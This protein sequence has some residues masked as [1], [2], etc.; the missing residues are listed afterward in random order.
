MNAYFAS[1]EQQAHPELRGKPVIITPTPCPTGC[2]ITSSYEARAYGIKTG[3]QVRE[4][5]SIYPHIIIRESDTFLY[6]KYHEKLIEIIKNL[7]PFYIVKSIDEL[8]IKLSPQDQNYKNS[9]KFALTIK[10]LIKKHLGAYVRCSIGIAPNIFLA[11][12]AAESKKPD[13]LTILHT[14]ELKS[15]LKKL[16]LTDLCGIAHR[17]ANNLQALGINSPSDFYSTDIQTLKDQLGKIGEYWCLN[18]HGYDANISFSSAP[19]KTISQSHVLEPRLRNWDLAWAVCEKLIFKAARRLRDH[20]LTPRKL[21]LGVSFLGEGRYKN[22][23]KINPTDDSFTLTK[24]IKSIWKY[25]PKYENF[26]L[27]VCIT[28]FDFVPS[29]PLQQ[30]LFDNL[31]KERSLSQ[32]ID[33]INDKF[34]KSTI[35]P[36]NVLL[37]HDSAPDRIS[38]GQPKI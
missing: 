19:P 26:P 2:I 3:M 38:F 4:A 22:W 28:F 14:Y 1:V 13:G 6:L 16:K 35:Y 5:Q 11:K 9:Q 37:A 34:T 15:F 7:T 36:A 33:K 29:N 17:M 18:L 24:Y 10:H 30:A 8:A 27:K 32:S 25:I 20:R 21:S 12:T 23:L 31:K